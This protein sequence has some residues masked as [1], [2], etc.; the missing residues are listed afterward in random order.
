[1]YMR[2]VVLDRQEIHRAQPSVPERS[3]FEVEMAT[4]KLKIHK[5]PG[6]HQISVE[7]VRAGENNFL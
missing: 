6:I 1:M 5:N 2:L 3:V 7:H 4:E